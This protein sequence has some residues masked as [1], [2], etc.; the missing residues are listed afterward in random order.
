M[1]FLRTKGMRSKVG[2]DYQRQFR[3]HSWWDPDFIDTLEK[4]G[5]KMLNLKLS[6]EAWQQRWHLSERLEDVILRENILPV[7]KYSRKA[8]VITDETALNDTPVPLRSL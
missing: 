2:D 7:E 5:R 1:T 6:P 8:N 3:F 4:A